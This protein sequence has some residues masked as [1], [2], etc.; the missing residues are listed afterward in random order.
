MDETYS[1]LLMSSFASTR[2]SSPWICGFCC[3]G[4]A[5]DSEL[6]RFHGA[7]VIT[8]GDGDAGD[9]GLNDPVVGSS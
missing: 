4:S 6:H 8:L 5:G 2:F 7:I 1:Y 9:F 3:M